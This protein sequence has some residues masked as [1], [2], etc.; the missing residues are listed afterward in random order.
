[1]ILRSLLALL[2]ILLVDPS[3]AAAAETWLVGEMTGSGDHPRTLFD[4]PD[5]ADL[6]RDRLQREPYATLFRGIAARAEQEVAL[7]D[8]EIGIEQ[9]K[10]NIARSAAYLFY[11]DRTV[12]NDGA[13]VPFPDE[14]ARDAMGLKAATY[15]RSMLTESRA[16]GIVDFI[17][18]IHT[19]QE[20]H[21]WADTLDLLLGADRDVLGDERGAAIQGV[22]DLAADFYAD[23]HA[24]NWI[25]TRSLVNNHR[26]KS[27][28]ALGLAAIV[29]NGE[30]FEVAF[31][32]GRYE[33]QR[34]MEFAVLNCDMVLRDIL[35][36]ADGG[37]A[38]AGGYLVYS[39]I[40]HVPFLWA[41]HRYT[42]AASLTVAPDPAAPPFHVLGL[43]QPYTIPDLWS[44]PW[45]ERQ[46]LWA[47]RTGMPDGTF[48]PYDDCTPGSAL[49]WGAF[50]GEEFE[51]A[52]LYRWAWEQVGQ[53][54]GGS[55]DTAPLL[56]ATYDDAIEARSPD[57]CGL[58]PH[59][60]LPWS[61]QVV[62]RSGW[63][64]D[65]TYAMLL[66]EHGKAASWAQTRWGQYIDG[67]GGHE[68]P[69]VGS[70]LLHAHGEPL[71]IDSGYLGWN[72]HEKV[73][74]V[75]NHN[76]IL[77]DGEGPDRTHLVVPPFEIDDD[78]GFVLLD[79]TLEGGWSAARDGQG[80][81]T[82]AEVTTPGVALAQVVTRYDV[83][84][85]ETDL[86]RRATFLDDRFLVLHDRVL[87]RDAEPHSITHQL[88]LNC[89]GTSGGELIL[90]DGGAICTREGAQLR[91]LVLSPLE[92]TQTTR[93]D[94]HDEWQWAERTHTVLETTVQAGSDADSG[95]R[96][97]TVLLPA[98]RGEG[99]EQPP[100]VQTG[101]CEGPCVAWTAAG[102]ECLAWTGFSHAVEVGG[103][104]TWTA[105]EGAYCRG[106]GVLSG[107]FAGLGDDQAVV[108]AR[109]VDGIDGGVGHW[110]V[111]MHGHDAA[112]P[113]GALRLPVVPEKQ[114]GGACDVVPA[115]SWWELT[116]PAGRTTETVPVPGGVVAAL[117]LDGAGLDDTPRVDLGDEVVLDAS[118][119]CAPAGAEP[120]YTWTLQLAPELVD[121]FAGLETTEPDL[122]WRPPLPGSY[123]AAV[124][125]SAGEESDFAEVRFS[126]EGEPAE[127]EPD[128][129]TPGE[130][131]ADGCQCDVSGES[132]SRA[133]DAGLIMVWALAVVL[134]RRRSSVGDGA[135]WAGWTA[136]LRLYGVPDEP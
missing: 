38:E 10:G 136:A 128:T 71:V 98:P 70:I 54:A 104:V 106:G 79:P 33:P 86:R 29:L 112:Q 37:Y 6:V 135:A 117:R 27:A 83:L 25:Y 8:H 124:R 73:N 26:S 18:D 105:R 32:D 13:I 116:L 93:E 22:A 48:P 68:H 53:V 57:E 20:L 35:S 99:A 67:A 41:W 84:A 110:W 81:L 125:V 95:A 30:D 107:T 122:T 80:Y 102:V 90:A 78:G 129:G 103:D 82:A 131:K 87:T 111:T 16:K 55:V 3:Q 34:W 47:I 62:F 65:A 115:D 66:C 52:A 123:R 17:L 11:L 23:F 75:T 28:A 119:S 118:A 4:G 114:P 120:R 49:F 1:V 127:A 56:L 43:E 59:Q 77:V 132:A 61:G 113:R 51:H 9:G 96:F 69:D 92:A 100:E 44:A 60:V 40:D 21:L 46:L 85:T 126:V 2:T 133:N 134:L 72:D 50:V 89:G 101:G 45:L 76:L 94:V 14:A 15:L 12:D 91:A 39:G 19:A 7:D 24:A 42:G 108:T 88:H 5:D 121:G 74:G 64:R 31:D 63:E 109:F 130:A 36:D 58:A 97:L